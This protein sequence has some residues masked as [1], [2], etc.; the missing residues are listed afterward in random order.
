MRLPSRQASRQAKAGL[1]LDLHDYLAPWP[2][3]RGR[4]VKHPLTGWRVRDDWP[5]RVPV[6]AGELDVFEAWFG[7]ILDELFGAADAD[8][9]PGATCPDAERK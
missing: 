6:T 7:D 5:E 3:K 2:P 4:P 8:R 1:V 9:E